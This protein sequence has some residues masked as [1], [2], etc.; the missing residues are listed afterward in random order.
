MDIRLYNASGVYLDTRTERMELSSPEFPAS[1]GLEVIAGK[2]VK[3]LLT[4]RGTDAFDSEY[5]GTALHTRYM[6]Q[7]YISKFALELKQDIEDCINYIHKSESSL[8]EGAEKLDTVTLVDVQ[9]NK[10]TRDRLDITLEIVT[11]KGSDALLH[12]QGG[13]V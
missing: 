10:N 11:N 13:T 2:V 3:Y 8:P 5:G 12:I 4:Y 7:Q 9:Y 1:T 6:S